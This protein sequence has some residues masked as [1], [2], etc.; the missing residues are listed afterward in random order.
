MAIADDKDG[1]VWSLFKL[2]PFRRTSSSSSVSAANWHNNTCP[3]SD[4]LSA[5]KVS[6]V[7]R[8]FLPARRRLKLDPANTL[9]FPYEP[10][11]QVR[12]AIKIKNT[13]KS[14]VAF[15]FQT[16]S[17]KTCFMRPPAAILAPGNSIIATVFKFV[18]HPE[19]NEKPTEQ[20]S[21]LK[22]KIMSLKVK[23]NVDYVPELFNEQKDQVAK[24]QILRVIFLDS[25]RPCPALEKLK[26]QLDEADAAVE[27]CKKPT[28]VGHS[29]IGEGLVV[30][31]WKERRDRYLGLQ[32][33]EGVDSA[34][35]LRWL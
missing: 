17:P 21:N 3:R 7:A 24:E 6:A 29:L 34:L 23:G 2:M 22:F 4:G 9:Y 1:K 15:K 13:S 19:N 30:D 32:Q 28:E 10:G 18:E 14:H 12:S 8:S 27:A 5:P 26:R 20:K 35:H 33:S 31:E 11:K 25:E 16:T